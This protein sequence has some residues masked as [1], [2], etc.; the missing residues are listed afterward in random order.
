MDKNRMIP[1]ESAK[2]SGATDA[3]QQEMEYYDLL[4]NRVR[5][6]TSGDSSSV[7]VDTARELAESVAYTLACAKREA[8]RRSI[9]LHSV[10]EA[11]S[12]G[13]NAI[14]Q[15]Y[16]LGSRLYRRAIETKLTLNN[17][18]YH[19]SLK[20][21]GA[22][23][24]RYD[25]EFFSR[26]IPCSIDYPLA[27]P[28]SKAVGVDY[29]CGW[30]SRIIAEN[31]FCLRFNPHAMHALHTFLY[32]GYEEVPINLYEPVAFAA[33]GL[34]LC[35]K[36]PYG[37]SMHREDRLSLFSTWQKSDSRRKSEMLRSACSEILHRF[38]IKDRFIANYL[39]HTSRN[40]AV[41]MNASSDADAFGMLFPETTE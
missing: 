10:S 30:L 8:D 3:S 22:F 34:T 33:L 23:F 36:E 4:A 26:E 21:V 25:A 39:L 16:K 12:L 5:Q 32:R 31:E 35:G 19:E 27:H 14:Q 40:L 20:E 9:R 38:R 15:K 7:P 11:F 18:C 37:L 28:I 1:S 6:Y 17:V 13:Q 2:Q 29:I 24:G 41:R